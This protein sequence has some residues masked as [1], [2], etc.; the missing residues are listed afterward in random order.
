ME[1]L[2]P[3]FDKEAC[4]RRNRIAALR[5]NVNAAPIKLYGST[6]APDSEET[7]STLIY[8]RGT[9]PKT[10]HAALARINALRPPDAK[11]LEA[12]DVWIHYAQAAN[13]NFVADRHM[14]LGSKTLKNIAADAATGVAFMNSHRTGSLSHPSELPF[15]KTFA[16]RYEQHKS[17]DGGKPREHSW[18]GMYM[19]RGVHP[20]GAAAPST[21]D[22][23]LMID[24]GTVPDV[25]VGLFG[26][27]NF[28]D[29]CGNE[30][31]GPDCTH[32][33]GTHRNMNDENKEAQKARGVCAAT[34]TFTYDDAHMTEV[35]AVY[36]GAVP[37]AG[38]RKLMR[39]SKQRQLSTQE[40]VQARTAYASLLSKG[41][42]SMQDDIEAMAQEAAEKGAFNAITRFFHKQDSTPQPNTQ[43]T[44]APTPPIEA[45]VDYRLMSED[46]GQAAVLM[47]R[48]A[49]LEAENRTAKADAAFKA[50]LNTLHPAQQSLF[51]AMHTT[52]SEIDAVTPRVITFSDA[53]GASK[54]ASLTALFTSFVDALPPHGLLK[55]IE[56]DGALTLLPG[57]VQAFSGANM[58]AA[59]QEKEVEKGLAMTPL[60]QQVLAARKNGGSDHK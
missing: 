10:E 52:L 1:T 39:L 53:A 55:P 57:S 48:I 20:N 49:E 31:E 22:L 13:D 47:S 56:G 46:S 51:T 8:A 34:A 23:H 36:D 3:Q 42:L 11:P 18:L 6:F 45:N 16:G 7:T 37:G 40:L 24:A 5:D 28:C 4:R 41:D 35:S 14:F 26:G 9:L 38:F 25:S 60:G 2:T 29:V 32:A 44:P 12:E 33:P 59:D 58:D 19:L 30:L 17:E 43:P 15:G 27:E 21:D 54:Q 50:R